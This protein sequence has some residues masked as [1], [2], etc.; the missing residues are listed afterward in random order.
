MAT[1]KNSVILQW[2][3]LILLVFAYAMAFQGSR[4]LWERDGS[5]PDRHM[6]KIPCL[7]LS[8]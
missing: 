8:T 1:R 7:P 3:F 4:A 2:L 5:R 6:E